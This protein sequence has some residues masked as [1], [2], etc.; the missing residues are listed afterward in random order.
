MRFFTRLLLASL[1]L[2]CS[3]AHANA[4]AI[5]VAT[6]G[7]NSDGSTW[8]K[9]KTTVV[10][11][12]AIAGAN[13]ILYVD[14]A[15]AETPAANTS[16]DAP[17]NIDLTIL[18]VTK[19]GVGAC[20]GSARA[21]GA[22]IHPGNTFTMTVAGTGAQK[23]YLYGMTIGA[24]SGS[25]TSN[26]VN[27]ATNL[28]ASQSRVGIECDH[29]TFDTP[30]T[31]SVS[32]NLGS[33][34][35]TSNPFP[36]IR[37]KDCTFNIANNTA[38]FAIQVRGA[39][40]VISNPTIAYAGASKPATL[41]L[42]SSAGNPLSSRLTVIDADLSTFNTSGGNYFNVANLNGHVIL[43]NVK[44]SSTP[45]LKT[46][47]WPGNAGDL[48]LVNV[49]TTNNFK[50]FE[51][52]NRLGSLTTNTSIYS[53]LGAA[54]DGTHLSWSVTTTAAA[55]E[56]EPFTLPWQMRWSATTSA[57]TA[58]LRIIRDN[59][60]A[61]T[62][63]DV[64]YE[65]EYG[66]NASFPQGTLA[67]GRNAAPFDGTGVAWTADTDSWTGTGGFTNANKQKL[68]ASITPAFKSVLRG[69]LLVGVAST[70]LY[71]DPLFRDSTGSGI[72][73]SWDELGAF[74]QPNVSVGARG[75]L[76]GH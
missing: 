9:A 64:W 58:G 22:Q 31:G 73:I 76:G 60:T 26:T 10:A 43:R 48:T 59:A 16:W 27:I 11:A 24:N 68:E 14:S 53:D 67:S 4:A 56:S 35:S 36:Y 12:M 62:N 40:V 8:A 17:S 30:G 74:A 44:L 42:T 55:N 75:I 51:Y 1:V 72:V 45:G 39:E 37:L 29:C 66:S 6:T 3:I 49:S 52:Y 5:C 20:A 65:I 18:S 63:R 46:G 23:L 2:F 61:L 15:Y 13:D 54:I 7:D 32:I 57:L 28:V 21:A 34:A 70:T 69:R 50:A 41:F 33:G 71:V 47:T 19:S 38:A 25:S